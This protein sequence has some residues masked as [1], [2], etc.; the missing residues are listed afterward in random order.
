MKKKNETEDER[1]EGKKGRKR[2]E[3]GLSRIDKNGKI[4]T[5]EAWGREEGKKKMES[6][7]RRRASPRLYVISA[8]VIQFAPHL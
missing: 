5:T 2:I 6:P 1:K 3:N 7:P 8:G 4:R